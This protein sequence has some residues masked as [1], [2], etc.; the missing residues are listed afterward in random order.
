MLKN[1]ELSS[2]YILEPKIRTDIWRAAVSFK[3]L[4][5]FKASF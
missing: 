4:A 5:Q 2:V 1:A 3:T